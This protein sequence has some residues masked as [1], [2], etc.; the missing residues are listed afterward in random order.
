MTGRATPEA[1]NDR[2][3]PGPA[4]VAEGGP[5]VL[6]WLLVV[7]IVALGIAAAVFGFFFLP[8]RV[9]SFPLPVSVLV[10]VAATWWL[11]R[12]SYR[13]TASMPAAIAPVAAWFVTTLVLY[14]VPNPTYTRPPRIYPD[15]W[16]ILVLIGSGCLAG[17]AS[18][19]LLWGDHLRRSMAQG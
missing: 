19:G 4:P 12:V 15:D 3:D 14:L 2:E 8:L 18:L 13:L 16:R 11:P 1:P 6:D 9:G 5:G 7:W 17:A 10:A